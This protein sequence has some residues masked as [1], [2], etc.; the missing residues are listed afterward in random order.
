M[1][2]KKVNYQFKVLYALGIIFI[3]AGHSG[4]NGGMDFWTNWFPLYS[5]HLGIFVFASGYF[6]SEQAENTIPQYIWKKIKRMV[7]PLYIWNVFYGVFVLISKTQGF[8]IGGDFTLRNL[9]LTPVLTGHQF[10]YNLGG[11][12]IIPLIGIEAF[13]VLFIKFLGKHFD[14]RGG[15]S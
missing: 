1:S 11:W 13:H 12:F 6:Y 2:D 14:T 9:L 10:I 3:V 5:F 7:I 15:Y 4:G 8:T